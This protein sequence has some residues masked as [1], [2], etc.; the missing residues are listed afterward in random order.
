MKTRSILGAAGLALVAGLLATTPSACGGGGAGLLGIATVGISAILAGSSPGWAV[1]D[2]N[3]RTP[4]NTLGFTS[5]STTTPTAETPDPELSP[6][7]AI[8]RVIVPGGAI[9]G[10]TIKVTT[11]A[12][13][14]AA[15]AGQSANLRC[16]LL[17]TGWDISSI[18]VVAVTKT[19]TVATATATPVE[20]LLDF[21]TVTVGGSFKVTGIGSNPGDFY[22]IKLSNVGSAGTITLDASQTKVEFTTIQTRETPLDLNPDGAQNF[23][24]EESIALTVASTGAA[25]DIDPATTGSITAIEGAVTFFRAEVTDASRGP[26]SGARVKFVAEGGSPLPVTQTVTTDRG[27]AVA[28]IT[29]RQIGNITVTATLL[30]DAGLD[31]RTVSAGS[32]NTAQFSATVVTKTTDRDWDGLGGFNVASSG[33][34][35]SASIYAAPALT[36]MGTG[37][38]DT[39]TPTAVIF[40]FARDTAS[41]SDFRYDVYARTRSLKADAKQEFKLTM[42]FFDQAGN[43]TG[44]A[45]TSAT[46]T[47]TSQLQRFSGTFTST[48]TNPL[49]RIDVVKAVDETVSGAIEL[50]IDLGTAAGD[51]ATTPGIEVIAASGAQSQIRLPGPTVFGTTTTRTTPFLLSSPDPRTPGTLR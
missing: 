13:G 31:P 40:L 2:P 6:G 44:S 26:V 11:S 19:A 34:L 27:Q 30:D 16:E 29:F 22:V 17:Y 51:A 4:V 41:G 32:T 28:G 18:F 39:A 46:L 5:V 49:A 21:N 42:E 15:T 35:G 8:D 33:N 50:T 36:V 45:L 47:A 48:D 23:K 25:D 1:L 20:F 37:T 12:T 7:E 9:L 24:L 10:N 14:S 3:Q 43:V 38:G